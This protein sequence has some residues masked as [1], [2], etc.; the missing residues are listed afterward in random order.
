MTDHNPLG[1]HAL[2]WT[3]SWEPDAVHR[4][5][6]GTAEAGYDLL[7]VPLLDPEDVDAAMTRSELDTAGLDATCSL[8]LDFDTDISSTDPAV[9][10][11]GAKLLRTA[12]DVTIAVGSPYLGGPIYSAMAKYDRPT[13]PQG[14]ANSAAVLRELA[15]EARPH[16][17]SLG[18][19]PVNRYESN[20]L[21]TIDQ[22]LAFIEEIG[23]D[24]VVVHVDTYHA[25]IEEHDLAAATRR[26]AD[27][28]RL[29]YVHI[30]ESHRGF[31]GTGSVAWEPFF[32]A[33]GEVDYRGPV[34]FES[35]SSAVVSDR[36][37][38]ALGVWRN[39]WDDSAELAS[40]AHAFMS[41]Q[42]AAS[43]EAGA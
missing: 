9:V 24:N 1:V 14:R 30:G 28:G 29:G 41:K 32:T 38:A 15:A 36:F 25:N 11:R 22:A 5:C 33:L 40:H 35:F 20:L 17:V 3:G 8:G 21:N 2:V 37:A 18:L 12:L 16:G 42:L 4:A 26:A 43:R 39:L 13:T 19:E 27:A 23:A 6:V 7:E 31:L 34:V 10:E